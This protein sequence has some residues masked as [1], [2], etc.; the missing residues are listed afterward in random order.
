MSE[1]SAT[2]TANRHA[3]ESPS[4]WH[5]ESMSHRQWFRSLSGKEIDALQ[6]M[7]ASVSSQVGDDANSLMGMMSTDFPL[8]AF[9]KVS[10]EIAAELRD[11]QGFCVIRTL[12]VERWSVLETMVAY[13]G[14][15]CQLGTPLPN[16]SRGDMIG[17]VINLGGDYTHANNRGY[18]SN[19][20]L[21]Y[22]VDQCDVVGLLC[23]RT[24]RH[25]GISKLVS[26]RAVYNS[27]LARRPDLLEI[28]CQPLHFSRMGEEEL[29]QTPWYVAPVFDFVDG[30]FH[31]A[32]GIN[33]IVKGHALP[34]APAMTALQSE[35]LKFFET[36]SEELEFSM[37][38][39]PGDIQFLNNGLVAHTRSEFTDWPDE[40]R[41]RHLLRIW[42][43]VPSIHQGAAYFENW[44][45]G[46]TPQ[47]DLKL[48]RES[49]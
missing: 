14:I 36:V 44:R 33:H 35:A 2:A 4:C 5:G 24:A 32:A 48:I 19:A 6:S 47:D 38:F 45:N 16:N 28:L 27:I 10:E 8:G 17:H 11:G 1:R 23:R 49:P 20:K 31:C 21:S 7:V 42:L 46:V 9:A 3:F 12:P 40:E 22:H 39:A 18:D 41:R 30:V 26:T 29:G 13:W 15:A 25:G 34:G 37:H 43:R